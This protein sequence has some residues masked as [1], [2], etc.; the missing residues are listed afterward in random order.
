MSEMNEAA[1]PQSAVMKSTEG[2]AGPNGLIENTNEPL[3]TAVSQLEVDTDLVMEVDDDYADFVEPEIQ[4]YRR[5]NR[6]RLLYSSIASQM[7]SRPF[8]EISV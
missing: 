5:P 2:W 8:D 6:S 3:P 4:W 1:Q 7:P